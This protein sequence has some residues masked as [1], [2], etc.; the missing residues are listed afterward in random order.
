[1]HAND[2]VIND[3]TTWEAVEGIAKLFPHFYRETAATFII[4]SVDTVDTGT[5]VITSQEEKVFWVLDLVGKEQTDHLQRLFTT[6][7]I[8]AK[9]EIVGLKSAHK[10][11]V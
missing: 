3:S 7:N 6:V 4:K 1:M 11:R 2:F 5:L 10:G 8:I 9:E